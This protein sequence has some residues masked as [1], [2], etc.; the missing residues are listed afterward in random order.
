M[1]P[2]S[3]SKKYR[4]AEQ[5]LCW[6]YLFPSTMSR[7][8]KTFNVVQRWS[9]SSGTLQKAIKRAIQIEG[10]DKHGGCHTFSHT[11]ATELLRAGY[12]ICTIQEL[13]GHKSMQTTQ[14]CMPIVKQ[15]PNEVR[16]PLN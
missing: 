13:L 7:M 9:T 5:A 10:V 11:F 1:V 6:Q 4:A 15:R 12:D 14:I 16:S 3:L 2:N 8:D